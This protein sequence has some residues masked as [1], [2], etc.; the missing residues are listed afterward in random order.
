MVDFVLTK[1]SMDYLIDYIRYAVKSTEDVNEQFE[2]VKTV[3]ESNGII[4]EE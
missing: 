1:E 4:E 3:L 2:S